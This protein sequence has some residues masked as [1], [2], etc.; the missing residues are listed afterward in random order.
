MLRKGG[1]EKLEGNLSN[2]GKE[3]REEG[4]KRVKVE[5]KTGKG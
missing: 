1:K 5:G 2:E 3:R 4:G